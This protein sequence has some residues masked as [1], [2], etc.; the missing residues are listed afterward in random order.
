MRAAAGVCDARS[1]KITDRLVDR[2]GN[3]HRSQFARPVQPGQRDE[4]TSRLD[5][6]LERETIELL[7]HVLHEQ[8]VGLVL[9]SH[10]QSMT[11]ALTDDVRASR[12]KQRASQYRAVD[13][14]SVA[15]KLRLR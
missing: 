13:T 4:P 10:N 1:H 11:E 5:P 8:G 2:I 9:V 15:K 14:R 12:S 6:I 3:P 7:L